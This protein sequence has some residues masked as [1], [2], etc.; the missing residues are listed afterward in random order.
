MKQPVL[1]VKKGAIIYDDTAAQEASEL[2]RPALPG[3]G[4]LW[5][6]RAKRRGARLTFLPLLVIALGL[7]ILFRV[8]PNVPVNRAAVSGWRVTLHVTPYENTLVVGVTFVSRAPLEGRAQGV[9]PGKD[10]PEATVRFSL[11]GTG[12]QAFV[13]GDLAKSP[14]TLRGELPW[15]ADAKR[16]QAEVSV[17]AGRIT[18]WQPA[19]GPRA[20]PSRE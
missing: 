10:L 15:I 16:V 17:G 4:P 2:P 18:L 1:R 14:M 8:V 9:Q 13:A 7:F 12:E 20:T 5:S 6:R 19:P 3:S 11:P